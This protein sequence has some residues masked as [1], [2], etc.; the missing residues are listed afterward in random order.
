MDPSKVVAVE[1]AVNEQSN[2]KTPSV[3]GFELE[4]AEDGEQVR[5]VR[6]PVVGEEALRLSKRLPENTF[7]AIKRLFG[8]SYLRDYPFHSYHDAGKQQ[9]VQFYH[10]ATQK[11]FSTEALMALILRQRSSSLLLV[12]IDMTVINMSC[13]EQQGTSEEPSRWQW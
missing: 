3:V 12:Y 5:K 6:R 9:S 11:T 7:S 13:N 1:M 2:R 10:T 8:V 4:E